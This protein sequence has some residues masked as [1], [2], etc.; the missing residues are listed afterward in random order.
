VCGGFPALP[1]TSVQVRSL[2]TPAGRPTG[3]GP[4]RTPTP[5]LSVNKLAALRDGASAAMLPYVTLDVSLQLHHTHHGGLQIIMLI[6]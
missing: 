4:D 5:D 6:T 2:P 1:T 3:S